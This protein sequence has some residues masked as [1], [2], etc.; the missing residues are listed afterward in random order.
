M[1]V[2][3]LFLISVLLIFS[4][5][6]VLTSS[7]NSLSNVPV[8]GVSLNNTA[9]SIPLAGTYRLIANIEPL[10]S[11]N[12]K[13]S[14][15]TSNGSIAA[16]NGTGLVSGQSVGNAEITVTTIAG[17]HTDVC[18]VEVYNVTVPVSGVGLNAHNTTII[19]GLVEHLVAYIY[20]NQASNQSVTWSTDNPSVA[21]VNE[22]GLITTHDI[23]TA[24]ITITTVDG[25]FFDQ[26]TVEVI[27]SPGS[28]PLPRM[29]NSVLF[30]P[31]SYP[32]DSS[33]FG[34]SLAASLNGTSIAVGMPDVDLTYD[35]EGAVI[36]FNWDGSDWIHET[37]NM[38]HT[39]TNPY[40]STSLSLGYGSSLAM[41]GD[42]SVI[43]SGLSQSFNEPFWI[44]QRFDGQWSATEM[45]GMSGEGLDISSDGSVIAAGH[46]YINTTALYG[47]AAGMVH[48][49]RY[50]GSEWHH[51]VD[52]YSDYSGES[53]H[54]GYRLDLS[55]DGNMLVVSDHCSLDTS[56]VSDN[57][58]H[59]F[60]YDGSEWLQQSLPDNGQPGLGESVSIS[61]DKNYIIVGAPWHDITFGNEGLCLLYA[62]Q[63]DDTW[64]F[65]EISPPGT[66]ELYDPYNFGWSVYFISDTSFVVGCKK[67]ISSNNNPV[68]DSATA[69]YYAYIYTI[70]DGELQ[71]E[72]IITQDGFYGDHFCQSFAALN[73]NTILIGA[74]QSY[75]ASI[76][77]DPAGAVYLYSY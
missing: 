10:V 66:Y 27:S 8:T 52:L 40:F 77:Y 75:Q 3:I 69:V 74:P 72:K 33:Y 61:P 29:Y 36:V 5:D 1:R 50:N 22:N 55:S 48:V 18:T 41:S 7:S 60:E 64:S 38:P 42:G 31:T 68:G 23:G 11:T 45:P 53:N 16:V 26:C 9:L 43:A 12:K 51:E 47:D 44:Y 19:T 65:V 56:A 21:S 49:Y 59:L 6:H 13:V 34:Y 46:C 25:G 14:W 63:P 4:C 76:D 2:Y 35:S 32:A 30:L 71:Y 37:I 67:Y 15:S 62:R 39:S 58:I 54:F 28:D 73:N 17:S 24:V 70:V 20:P 57:T